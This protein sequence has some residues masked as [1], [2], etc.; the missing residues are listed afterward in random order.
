[1]A[2]IGATMVGTIKQVFKPVEQVEKG[3]E[4]GYFRFGGSSVVLL[5]EPGKII[6]DKDLVEN[7]KNGLETRVFMGEGVAK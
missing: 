4:K 7:T 6:L 3:Q 5:F 1:M 2:E